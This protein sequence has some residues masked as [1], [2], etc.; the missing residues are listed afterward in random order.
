MKL[1]W[2]NFKAY[3]DIRL[4]GLKNTTKVLVRLVILRAEI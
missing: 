2:P 3:P 1:S 4:K